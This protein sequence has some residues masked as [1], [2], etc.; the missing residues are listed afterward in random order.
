M[1]TER[2]SVGSILKPFLYLI[3][4]HSHDP[5]DFILD[6]AKIYETEED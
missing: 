4:L 3:A 1:I 2:R 6:E 5:N